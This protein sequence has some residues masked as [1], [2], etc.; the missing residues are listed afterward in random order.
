MKR[1]EAYRQKYINDKLEKFKSEFREKQYKSLK[2]IV[3]FDENNAKFLWHNDITADYINRE[4]SCK[5]YSDE[6][7]TKVITD[8]IVG[9]FKNDDEGYWQHIT[10]LNIAISEKDLNNFRRFITFHVVPMFDEET[11]KKLDKKVESFVA[12]MRKEY[13]SGRYMGD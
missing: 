9:A 11:E 10:A 7:I 3:D 6:E 13:D 8:W 1:S 12:S 2:K 4:Y 5:Y